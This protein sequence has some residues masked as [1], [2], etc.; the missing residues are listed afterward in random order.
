M[1]TVFA[2]W[3]TGVVG[4]AGMLVVTLIF[5]AAEKGKGVQS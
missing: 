5:K 2:I 4:L 1:E 3:L